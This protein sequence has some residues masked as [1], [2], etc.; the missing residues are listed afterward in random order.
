MKLKKLIETERKGEY[1]FEKTHIILIELEKELYD[2]ILDITDQNDDPESQYH[3]YGI[4]T[5]FDSDI[6][7]IN[8]DRLKTQL[9]YE[10][11]NPDEDSDP[12]EYY[13][14]LIEFLNKYEGYTLWW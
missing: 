5:G 14:N 11:E 8:L 4:S 1:E 3:S 6:V 10:I 7:C 9:E 12:K 13:K 2:I